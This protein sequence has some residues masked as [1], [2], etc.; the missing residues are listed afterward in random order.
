M[1]LQPIY[2]TITK[3]KNMITCSF[4]SYRECTT[5]H[6]IVKKS[7][8]SGMVTTAM[9]DK[10]NKIFNIS[11]GYFNTY[12]INAH[13]DIITLQLINTY[14]N[15]V[16]PARTDDPT[17][18]ISIKN[19]KMLAF[20]FNKKGGEI[21]EEI[22]KQL[23]PPNTQNI[24]F[25]IVQPIINYEQKNQSWNLY[26]HATFIDKI[27]TQQGGILYVDDLNFKIPT[28]YKQSGIL[29]CSLSHFIN[30]EKMNY[31]NEQINYILCFDTGAI[32]IGET[33]N[34]LQRYNGDHKTKIWPDNA[35]ISSIILLKSAYTQRKA[36]EDYII[37]KIKKY[38][39]LNYNKRVDNLPISDKDQ[40]VADYLLEIVL[41]NLK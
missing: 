36:I 41:K 6:K 35:K 20:N 19:N 14:K 13:N 30:N 3:D 37:K 38:N 39:I 21:I 11:P 33:G 8:S 28:I 29:T 18:S 34:F 2:S 25:S 4:Q 23:P 9:K 22:S 26:D 12:K 1:T 5:T 10:L 16:K 24:L 17:V 31:I 7:E 27:H 32:Y 15:S 40:Q